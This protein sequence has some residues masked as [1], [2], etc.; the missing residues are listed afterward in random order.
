LLSLVRD[1]AVSRAGGDDTL[2]M[3]G[4]IRDALSP[5]AAAVPSAT[6]GEVFDIVHS[7]QEAV[8]H[9]ANPQLAFEVML[10]KIGDAYER[11]LQRDRQ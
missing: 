6:L 7:T 10:F 8:A 9:N 1:L 11:A 3:H 5:L 4:D 2:L